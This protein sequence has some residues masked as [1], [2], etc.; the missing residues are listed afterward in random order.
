MRYLI[1][2]ALLSISACAPLN[3][4]STP[5]EKAG[6]VALRTVLFPLTLGFSELGFYNNYQQAQRQGAYNQWYGTL[7]SEEKDRE[8]RRQGDAERSLGIALSGRSAPVQAPPIV[9]HQ[10]P[11][12][13]QRCTTTQLGM[14][15]QTQC[16]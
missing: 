8:V 14:H 2:F 1:L 4:H 12:Q 15:W 3:P 16:Y 13:P 9:I 7:S 10:A 11:A 5:T 6:E